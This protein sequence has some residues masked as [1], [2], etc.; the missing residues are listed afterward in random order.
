M[1]LL[2]RDGDRGASQSKTG[3]ARAVRSQRYKYVTYRGDPIEQL[4]DLEMDPGEMDNLATDSEAAA[5]LEAHRRMLREW[6]TNSIWLR[7][8]PTQTTG[9]LTRVNESA[10]GRSARMI[11]QPLCKDCIGKKLINQAKLGELI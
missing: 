8:C 5:I 6:R 10:N 2:R 7:A 1:A 9:A 11:A 3:N 4:F